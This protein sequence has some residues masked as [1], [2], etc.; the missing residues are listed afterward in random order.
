MNNNNDDPIKKSIS[1]LIEKTNA[2]KPNK[3]L[4]LEKETQE[5]EN[6][7]S[8]NKTTVENTQEK[9]L[10][11]SQIDLENIESEI[12]KN[13][14]ETIQNDPSVVL[15][16]ACV[17]SNAIP[18]LLKDVKKNT[19]TASTFDVFIV[20]EE[21]KINSYEINH[22]VE[23]DI[24][25]QIYS[26][27]KS[28][29][30]KKESYQKKL[31]KI[32]KEI[33]N[34]HVEPIKENQPTILEIS[35]CNDV[36]DNVLVICY[37]GHGISSDK[38]TCAEHN[39][40]EDHNSEPFSSCSINSDEEGLITKSAFDSSS[41][42]VTYEATHEETTLSNSVTYEEE[43]K[44]IKSLLEEENI[45]LNLVVDNENRNIESALEEEN[46]ALNTMEEIPPNIQPLLVGGNMSVRLVKDKPDE[47]KEDSAKS[48]LEG[49]HVSI[50]VVEKKL[51]PNTT[52]ASP[53]PIEHHGK[54]VINQKDI[55]GLNEEWERM[56]N[57]KE[58]IDQGSKKIIEEIAK[59]AG[60]DT[61]I[62]MGTETLAEVL[63]LG[64]SEII[65]NELVE[66]NSKLLEKENIVE[67][68]KL[69]SNEEKAEVA[70]VNELLK[71]QIKNNPINLAPNESDKYSTL[72]N[73]NIKTSKNENEAE[74]SVK[75]TQNDDKSTLKNF[76]IKAN[77]SVEGSSNKS[78]I[79]ESIKNLT[80]ACP[81][82]N[83]SHSKV[84]TKSNLLP[85]EQSNKSNI[86]E[87]VKN[88][89]NACPIDNLSHSKVATKSN[90][91]VKEQSNKS[92]LNESVKN[93]TNACPVDV[94]SQS[95]IDTNLNKSVK[96]LSIKPKA[97]ST[98]FNKSEE[99]LSI[100]SISK[101]VHLNESDRASV[102]NLTK[103]SP[104]EPLISSKVDSSKSTR[105]EK[106]A[107]VPLKNS[108]EIS[109]KQEVQNAEGPV[110]YV[111][112]EINLSDNSEVQS[113]QNDSDSNNSTITF[114]ENDRANYSETLQ[115]IRKNK[116]GN[117]VKY[118]EKLNKKNN[119]NK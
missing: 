11:E 113:I 37:C 28:P 81:I 68:E 18:E 85:K 50:D 98:S 54:N 12:E 31:Q 117:L 32:V 84:A 92:N 97:T 78:N 46:K 17:F 56:I 100:R 71:E 10:H 45:P 103:T 90:L 112:I 107:T 87:S 24:N 51:P 72:T 76:V 60:E 20:N 66:H 38:C 26:T 82:D 91:S 67:E 42:E 89:T 63:G 43:Y 7:K 74:M 118:Y 27:I 102:R 70:I 58:T 40:Y 39:Y 23:D 21:G 64:E 96:D 79:N 15:G 36:K 75:R 49:E 1:R 109:T 33:K 99:N 25:N 35:H 55:Y 108:S 41:E 53:C 19:T 59:N 14:L 57:N 48:L 83:L 110:N 22:Y 111:E 95:K 73:F 69:I 88:L 29:N 8:T 101:T 30:E 116:V 106:E 34:S 16:A 65:V 114:I 86:N 44:K 52:C 94:A 119:D 104:I 62:S 13:K 93:L 9:S 115:N 80:N 105:S 2:N 3:T 77:S 61:T 5:D 6:L 47:S 4:P